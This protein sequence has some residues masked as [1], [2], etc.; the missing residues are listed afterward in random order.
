MLTIKKNS[1]LNVSYARTGKT[2]EGKGYSMLKFLEKDNQPADLT[3]P[4]R[5]SKPVYAWFDGDFPEAIKGV[6]DRAKVK[7]VD[8]EG[9]DSYS[10]SR[11]INGKTQWREELRLINPVFAM[12]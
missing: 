8:F 10:T 6:K 9:F 2:Q 4:S 12:A 3:N 11:E 7:L 5:S 1:I